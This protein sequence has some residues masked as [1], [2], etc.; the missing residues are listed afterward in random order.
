MAGGSDGFSEELEFEGILVLVPK[1]IDPRCS[2]FQISR[3]VI[4]EFGFTAPLT[5]VSETRGSWY[6]PL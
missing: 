5:S 1:I 4:F 2:P 3:A 6:A